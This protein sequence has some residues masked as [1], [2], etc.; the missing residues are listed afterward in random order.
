MFWETF[1]YS[2]T[3]ALTNRNGTKDYVPVRSSVSSVSRAEHDQS[4]PG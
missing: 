3:Y 4:H 1:A 2:Q